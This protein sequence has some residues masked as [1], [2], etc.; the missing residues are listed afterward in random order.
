MLQPHL[1]EVSPDAAAEAVPPWVWLIDDGPFWSFARKIVERF[2]V[3]FGTNYGSDVKLVVLQLLLR[4]CHAAQKQMFYPPDG[5]S[6]CSEAWHRHLSPVFVR[7]LV[8]CAAL[9]CSE[10]VGKGLHWSVVHSQV[11]C[12]SCHLYPFWVCL[13]FFFFYI[14]VK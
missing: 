8:L 7:M 14:I 12:E 1:S 6:A 3:I 2:L 4:A 10:I 5:T 9:V 11:S 13:V